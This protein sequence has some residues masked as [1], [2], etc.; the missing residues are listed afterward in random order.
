MPDPL[1]G[2]ALQSFAPP[3]QP[4]AVSGVHALLSLERSSDPPEDHRA[5]RR[6]R[7][8]APELD[9]PHNGLAIETPPA[10]R[11]LLHT[12]VRHIEPAV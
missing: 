2:F 4:Y 1:M 6:R 3:V 11:A 10:F 5:R 9:D 7:N 12:R 8:A